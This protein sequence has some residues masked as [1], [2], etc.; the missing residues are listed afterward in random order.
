[1]EY[2]RSRFFNIRFKAFVLGLAL[3]YQNLIFFF[4]FLPSFYIEVGVSNCL[5][6]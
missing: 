6:L 4:F 5:I 3:L 2:L 1:M